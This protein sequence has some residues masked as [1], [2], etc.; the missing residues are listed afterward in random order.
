[1]ESEVDVD[2]ADEDIIFVDGDSDGCVGGD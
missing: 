2:E 1:V